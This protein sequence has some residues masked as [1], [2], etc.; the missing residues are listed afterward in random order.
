[1]PK[2]INNLSYNPAV[3]HRGAALI[4]AMIVLV[5]LTILGLAGMSSSSMELKMSSNL[6]QQTVSFQN[7]EN[8][9]T[10]AE[11]LIRTSFIN[12]MDVAGNPT[13]FPITAGYYNILGGAAVPDIASRNFWS[14]AANSMD[15]A[16]NRC[17][18]EYLGRQMILLEDKVTSANQYV[19]RITTYGKSTDGTD[20]IVQAVFLVT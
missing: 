13:T 20:S 4:I 3:S 11:R 9:R 16:G 14:T 15:C 18:I 8:G 1:M 17:T 5:L 6:Q 12:W 2:S 19:F 10:F 7:S